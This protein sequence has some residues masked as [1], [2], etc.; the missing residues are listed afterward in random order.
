MNNGT[1]NAPNSTYIQAIEVRDLGLQPYEPIWRSMQ[2]YTAN[3][4]AHSIDMIWHLEHEAVYTIG[5]NGDSKHLLNIVDIP[6]IKVDR[7][8]QITYH[9]PGQLIIYFLIDLRRRRHPGIKNIVSLLEDTV[10]ELLA[11]YNIMAHKIKGA[12][13]VYVKQKKIAALGIRVKKLG[14]YHGLSLNVNMDLS[15]YNVINP[16][17]YK[18][19]KVT[20]IADLGG[21]NQVDIVANDLTK[22]LLKSLK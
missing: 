15:P 9:G 20:Q 22:R 5:L 7:G 10:I 16:C 19:L 6:V 11:Q 17:G 3:R 8:G 1:S 4:N 18:G 14:C 12:P 2:D 13:G 21:P